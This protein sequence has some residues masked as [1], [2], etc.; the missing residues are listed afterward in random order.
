MRNP[1]IISPAPDSAKARILRVTVSGV[2]QTMSSGLR[3]RAA[4]VLA[5]ESLSLRS[6]LFVRL[7]HAHR[8]ADRRTF[9]GEPIVSALW[10]EAASAA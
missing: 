10:P 9:L 1:Q 2:R 7:R 4:R 3:A 8:L 6:R 5:E